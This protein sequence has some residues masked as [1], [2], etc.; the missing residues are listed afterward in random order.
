VAGPVDEGGASSLLTFQIANLDSTRDG[1]WANTKRYGGDLGVVML[2]ASPS[3]I[4]G[5]VIRDES[6]SKGKPERMPLA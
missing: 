4:P 6:A 1:N 3:T 5:G 2:A